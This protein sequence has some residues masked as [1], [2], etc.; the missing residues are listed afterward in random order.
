MGGASVGQYSG[1]GSVEEF[2]L[3]FDT[4]AHA[5]RW[6]K[7]EKTNQ[8]CLALSGAALRVVSGL[9]PNRTF[10]QIRDKLI[11][12]YGAQIQRVRYEADLKSR[13]RRPGES[14]Q[15]L[16]DDI[17]YLLPLAHPTLDAPSRDHIGMSAFLDALDP[18]L[19]MTVK[20]QNPRSM[21]EARACAINCEAIKL[22]RDR[23]TANAS[24]PTAQPTP[25]TPAVDDLLSIVRGLST[26]WENFAASHANRR[27]GVQVNAPLAVAQA[28]NTNT[29]DGNASNRQG[30]NQQRGSNQSRSKR[31]DVSNV[32]CFECNGK[33]HLSTSTTCP[34]YSERQARLA[35]R[36]AG[37]GNSNQATSATPANSQSTVTQPS[38][39]VNGM[40]IDNSGMPVMS[41]AA[42]YL[43]VHFGGKVI[44]ALLDTGAEMSVVGTCLLP[45]AQI[46]PTQLKLHAANGTTIP[47]RGQLTTTVSVGSVPTPVN[48]LVSD[49]IYELILGSDWLHSNQCVW[50]FPSKSLTVG[51]IS[52]RLG[53]HQPAVT[54]MRRLYVRDD[55]RIPGRYAMSIPTTVA[56]R[57]LSDGCDNYI[58]E[59]CS[60]GE[61][62]T[63]SRLLISSN[64]TDIT[65]P[66]IN[67]SDREIVLKKGTLLAEA[68]P[69]ES[70]DILQSFDPSEPILSNDEQHL[71]AVI[72]GLPKRLS[73]TERRE[74]IA[75]VRSYA[76]LFSKDEYD[77]G[78]TSVI[79]HEINTGQA[80]P[81]KQQMRRQPPAYEPIIEESMDKMT[82]SG[83]I[84]PASGPFGSNITM[85][86]KSNGALR[87][88]IDYRQLNAIT[89]KDSYPLP[90]IDACHDALSGCSYFSTLDM[91]SGYW[92]VPLSPETAAKTAFLSRRGLHQ[93]N[94]L[95]F[96][97]TN[98]PAI[99][100]RLMDLVLAGLTWEICL[101]FLDDIIVMSRDFKEHIRR[102][103]Q[104]FDRLRGANLK[105]N[106]SKCHLF[107]SQVRFLGSIIS[108]E[109]IAPD[110]EKLKAIREWPIPVKTKDVRAFTALAG[111]YRR[112][113]KGFAHIAKPLYALQSPKVSFH[114]LPEHQKAFET[115]QQALSSAPI[116]GMPRDEG[117]FVLDTDASDL[118]LGAVLSQVQDGKETV[119]AYASQVLKPAEMHYCTT[120]KELLAVMYGLTQFR[121]YLLGRTFQI[122]TDHAALTSLMTTPVPLGQQARWLDL[123][124]EFPG[125]TIVHRAGTSHSNADGLSRRPCEAN[126]KI[127]CKQCTKSPKLYNPCEEIYDDIIP[128]WFAS[129][130]DMAGKNCRS[131]WVDRQPDV[132]VAPSTEMFTPSPVI[133]S[134]PGQAPVWSAD[135]THDSVTVVTSEWNPSSA[136]IIP[137]SSL[138][139]LT[140]S[141]MDSPSS[142]S[143]EIGKHTDNIGVASAEISKGVVD[144][145]SPTSVPL[146]T[147]GTIATVP[148]VQN[149]IPVAYQTTLP[150]YS[151]MQ[152]LVVGP[153]DL[154]SP[155]PTPVPCYILQPIQVQQPSVNST[156]TSAMESTVSPD[157]SPKLVA[158]QHLAATV[159]TNVADINSSSPDSLSLTSLSVASPTA[160]T[161]KEMLPI[162]VS[163]N[164]PEV[165]PPTVR[166]LKPVGV[167]PGYTDMD[168]HISKDTLRLA[169]RAD[170]ILQPIIQ[171]LGDESIR[172]NPNQAAAYSRP[173]KDI[174]AQR[175]SLFFAEDILYR[176]FE[177]P[178][179]HM[180]H[181]QVL[182][183][184]ELQDQ[185]VQHI[186][187]ATGFGHFGV[188]KTSKRLQQYAYFPSWKS[189]VEKIVRNCRVCATYKHGPSHKQGAL[190]S[191]PSGAP[192]EKFHVDLIGPLPRSISGYHYILT[193]VC[194]FTKYLVTVPLR[195]KTALTVAKALVK[196]VY[197]VYGAVDL[198][199]TDQGG[200][201]VNEIHANIS[202]LLGIKQATT[203]SYHPSCNGVVERSH[204]T[205]H[206]IFAKT[207]QSNQKDWCVQL[208]YVTFAYNT[209]IHTATHFSPFYLMFGRKPLM[210]IDMMMSNP[211]EDR[212]ESI[213]QFTK[214]IQS[215]FHSAYAIVSSQ[216]QCAFDRSKRRYDA[217]VK[218]MHFSPGDW[219]WFYSPR[220]R[221]KCNRKWQLKTTGP[222][223]ICK[224]INAVNYTMKM[225]PRGRLVTVHI[226]KITPYSGI[227]PVEWQRVRK[228]LLSNIPIDP[229]V[230]G[231]TPVV[232]DLDT[233]PYFQPH[234]IT[235][236]P[237]CPSANSPSTDMSAAT[238]IPLPIVA[239]LLDNGIVN[240]VIDNE[241]FADSESESPGSQVEKPIRP[242]R[243]VRKPV[244]FRKLFTLAQ[245]EK[246]C[247]SVK[248]QPIVANDFLS[249][250][251]DSLSFSPCIRP[252]RS[253][254]N[255]S[256]FVSPRFSWLDSVDDDY[257][258]IAQLF[259]NQGLSDSDFF[260]C[261]NTIPNNFSVVY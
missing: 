114:W 249:D 184:T 120:R 4:Y 52:H 256:L 165:I 199:V 144:P 132:S 77:I 147:L 153:A 26:Q 183:P 215:R 228:N 107:Q 137:A 185:F 190:Q 239:D 169:Q 41:K 86:R 44:P 117:N 58:I 6:T 63:L 198:Q 150:L 49:H 118:A 85:V 200:E 79:Q 161:S 84:S 188:T 193:G 64:A 125:K 9:G 204:A 217:R 47:L 164:S 46:A 260:I 88:C 16:Y 229:P 243:S 134:V 227:V 244:R 172:S 1:E 91:R 247:A 59:P 203:T 248:P 38:A 98:A 258:G 160:A 156:G 146:C 218:E 60:F 21:V 103:R 104:V 163:G 61:G 197:L 211:P 133:P 257:L 14:I 180:I 43:L 225:S 109:G 87:F 145:V 29:I 226:D 119:I 80:R 35:R 122:R 214:D 31:T 139:S 236:A 50:D 152:V 101:A 136:D 5:I 148:S 207:I 40:I 68:N 259:N 3:R 62:V 149:Q 143:N 13:Q 37:Q 81:F 162:T 141:S 127:P 224:R 140:A 138:S 255:S 253:S 131:S 7:E 102:L 19:V 96:G 154:V 93:F 206:S 99:F 92:Q 115:L 216:L 70:S 112:H 189:T 261:Q 219:V 27:D 95:P 209:S 254:L 212:Y 90:R 55:I 111:Y 155:S 65:V 208:P 51:G 67:L 213:D 142:I 250:F 106:P 42:V 71:Q 230:I 73:R 45:D 130:P 124:A 223:L 128:S 110:P 179:G 251:G 158:S 151:L 157:H 34:K 237:L 242:K 23:R 94:V 195:D 159:L 57:T 33:G 28:T 241:H 83:V 18:D 2:L 222:H 238:A 168:S 176:R 191:Q 210:N 32:T 245:A 167:S 174:W 221:P 56:R 246:L 182:L 252:R 129:P 12:K 123:L 97:L 192:M 10:Q 89:V 175:D 78:R 25:R 113:I 196:S 231:P 173:V 201:F 178:S 105:L 235:S 233:E 166:A 232:Q 69:I 75:F 121:H 100:Q 17:D 20:L 11:D 54:K 187:G 220:N 240:Q 205:I 30:G 76:T 170:S 24:V 108:G 39:S 22:E 202:K 72:D 186:H 48:L 135:Q 36:A 234:S 53:V 171:W 177:D 82:K 15:S 66:M 181:S 74:A 194:N 8:L 116:V 126:T